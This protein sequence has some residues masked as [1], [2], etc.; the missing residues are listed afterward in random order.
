MTVRTFYSYAEP[1][2]PSK[3]WVGWVHILHDGVHSGAKMTNIS[4]SQ[5]G[6]E[7]QLNRFNRLL[8]KCGYTKIEKGH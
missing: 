2:A 8:E 3:Y 7:V 4:E 1:A 5:E 6:V